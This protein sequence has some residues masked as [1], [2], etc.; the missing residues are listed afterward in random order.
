MVR[1]TLQTP[2]LPLKQSFW[3]AVAGTTGIAKWKT[4]QCKGSKWELNVRINCADIQREW[5]V[6]EGLQRRALKT[7]ACFWKA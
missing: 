7:T 6:A 2:P 3:E 5:V 4:E 1:S